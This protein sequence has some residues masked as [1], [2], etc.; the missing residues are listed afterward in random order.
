MRSPR[1]AANIIAAHGPLSRLPLQPGTHCNAT[2]LRA[3]ESRL[4]VRGEELGK[5]RRLLVTGGGIF[6]VVQYPRQI[7]QVLRFAV[8]IEQARKN[9][10]NFDMALQPHQI[11]PAHES[12]FIGLHGKPCAEQLLPELKCPTFHPGGWPGD[13]TVFQQRGQVVSHRPRGRRP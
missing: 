11:E 3:R 8:T 12:V 2:L 9:A 1:P 10:Q 7:V 13:V 4:D 5:F 6:D